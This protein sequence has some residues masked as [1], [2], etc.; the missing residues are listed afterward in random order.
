[1]GILRSLIM[2]A[3]AQHVFELYPDHQTSIPVTP[4]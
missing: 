4:Q 3:E 2:P 1:M